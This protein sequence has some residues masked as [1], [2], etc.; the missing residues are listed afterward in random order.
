MS[1]RRVS[2]PSRRRRRSI[3][4]SPP[5][6]RRIWR[7]GSGCRRRHGGRPGAAAALSDAVDPV[8]RQGGSRPTW[9]GSPGASTA[10]RRPPCMVDTIA[11]RMREY[12]GAHGRPALGGS[13]ASSAP[14]CGGT[15]DAEWARRAGPPGTASTGWRRSR[16]RS[17]SLR[18]AA[19][20]A[21]TPGADPAAR[22]R[23]GRCRS[24]RARWPAGPAPGGGASTRTLDRIRALLAKA[25][26]TTF[27]EEAETYT[28]KAQELMARHSIDAALL[29]AA[30]PHH[31]RAGA[32]RIGVDAP[33]EMAKSMLLSVVAEANRCRSVW[34]K[35]LGFE[36]RV[37]LRDRPGTGRAAVH[38]AAGAGH[39]GDDGEGSRRD[40]HGR[41]STRS[42]RQ[43][44]LTAYANRIGERLSRCHRTRQRARP[45]RTSAAGAA[46]GAGR[47]RRGGAGAASRRC[48][49]RWRHR[50][51]ERQQ[52][53]RLGVR[54]GRRRPRVPA[55]PREVRRTVTSRCATGRCSLSLGTTCSA[56][57]VANSTGCRSGITCDL[58]DAERGVRLG[59]RRGTRRRR[60]APAA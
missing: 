36:H 28:A 41:S 32:V 49:R 13:S 52:P 26:S 29:D 45:P 53:R 15:S 38:V 34:S 50:A 39:G 20:A 10:S 55:T 58:G 37:R 14:R 25:E 6:T 16:P 2:C 11:G 22:Q 19:P 42:F 27:P 56:M 3:R 43:S 30:G 57:P 33:Y 31:G 21:A 51:G 60:P 17:T 9:S 47:P 35:A 8:W 40:R 23:A 7:P 18:L 5:C 46:A 1:T 54:P 4:R 44:F 12:S 24:A 48:S 59:R